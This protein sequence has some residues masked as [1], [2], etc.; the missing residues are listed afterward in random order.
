MFSFGT[1]DKSGSSS[2]GASGGGFT[3]SAPSATGDGKKDA[4]PAAGGFSFGAPSGTE[5]SKAPA[6]GGLFGGTSKTANAP[7][8]APST[9]GFSFGAPATASAATKTGGDASK[10]PAFSFGGPTPAAAAG[11][12]K[13]AAPAGGLFGASSSAGTDANLHVCGIPLSLLH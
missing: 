3:F 5:P 8:P 11:D 4:A 1:T 10:P 12:K 7:A 13:D 6:P 2:A 9:G